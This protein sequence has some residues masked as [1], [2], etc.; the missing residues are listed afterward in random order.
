[1][2]TE[3]PSK[4]FTFRKFWAHRFGTAPIL[5]TSREE[6]DL[7]G[8]DSCD[9]IFVTG[10][11]YIDHPSFAAGILGRFLEAQGFRVG[12]VP[13]PRWK[14]DED[15]LALG[16]PNLFW[17][18]NAG[19]MDSMVNHY[20]SDK[21]KRSD[22]AY[23]PDGRA[24][25]RPD[26]AVR[27][28]TQRCRKISPDTPIVIGGIEASLRRIAHY[29]YWENRVLPS[30]L[31]DCPADILS[32][33]NGERSLE[34]IAHGL[35][36]GWALS[37]FVGMPGIAMRL[38]KL[39]ESWKVREDD[40][41]KRSTDPYDV[42]RLPAYEDVSSDKFAFAVASRLQ[43]LETRPGGHGLVQR[44]GN[45]E[46]WVGNIPA[47]LS[48]AEMDTIYGL[49]FSRKPHPR[50]EGHRI[51][52]FDM[53]K[54]SITIMRGC[55]GG[56]A[57]CSIAAHEGRVIQSRSE[58][59]ICEEARAICEEQ[60]K[61][62]AIISDV[63]GPSANMYR[64]NAKDPK[65]CELC[66]RF[67]CLYPKPCPNMNTDHQPLRRLYSKIRAMSEVSHLFI[68]SGIRYDLALLDPDY[69]KDL[70][71]YH[72][73]GYLKI[74]PEHISDS[75]LKLMMKPGHEKFEAFCDYFKRFSADIGKKQYIVPYFIAAHPGCTKQDMA[76]I[77]TWLRKHNMR[78]EQAQTF[79]PTPMSASTT[80][81][82]TGYNPLKPLQRDMPL[83]QSAKN[84]RDR[85]EQ[86][87]ILL[88]Q[89]KRNTIH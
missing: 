61:N 21:R 32:F 44:H 35:S 41:D 69:I 67:S 31:F 20:T 82:Y 59:S 66:Q 43:M 89:Q 30:I 48:T 57:F 80:M 3:M 83:I 64:M 50:Y 68:G 46:L 58:D 72:V 18:I 10:D 22:D 42:R 49:P 39:P 87:N 78:A 8:W 55:F 15:F 54:N 70:V 17:A 77:A 73:S 37:D 74:A 5:P 60:R 52:A 63:G 24:G 25:M 16:I 33:G 47:P 53:I 84:I 6:M 14:S 88:T 40:E 81:Y 85:Q 19:N 23:S 51:P 75:V 71:K 28:Y 79:L 65:K 9:I 2:H 36:Y 11:A 76:E 86:K 38:P 56:C 13:Q 26:R 4:L 7:L 45:E 27:V 34:V 29:D 62:H 12:I 1:M